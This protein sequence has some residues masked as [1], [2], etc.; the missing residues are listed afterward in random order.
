LVLKTAQAIR[1]LGFTAAL[2]YGTSRV[3]ERWSSRVRLRRYLIVKQDRDLLPNMPAGYQVRQ[4]LPGDTALGSIDV[5]PDV[6]NYR[7]NQ[8]AECLSAWRGN[9]ICGV[10]WLVRGGFGEDEV[11]ADFVSPDGDCWDLGLY[12]APAYRTGRAI[13]ALW[14]AAKGWMNDNTCG[15]SWSRIADR[16]AASLASQRR[17]GATSEGSI[18]FLTVGQYEASFSRRFGGFGMRRAPNRRRFEFLSPQR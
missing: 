9:E 13:V 10:I 3:L 2:V 6:Q 4:L 14:A 17:L 16:N 18:W 7:F 5:G 1:E 8:G 12:V 11:K 15:S